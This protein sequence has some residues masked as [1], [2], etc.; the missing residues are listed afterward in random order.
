MQRLDFDFASSSPKENVNPIVSA[1]GL[2]AQYIQSEL[3]LKNIK[4]ILNPASAVG[5]IGPSGCGKSTLLRCLNLLHLPNA[6]TITFKSQTTFDDGKI[7]VDEASLR[8]SIGLV[9][10]GFNLWPNKD[11][12]SNLIE[13]PIIVRRVPR[14]IAVDMAMTNLRELNLDKF[15]KS[16]PCEL[17]G[18]Q[19]QKVALMRAIIMEPE[20]LLLDEITSALDVE[21]TFQVLEI[22]QK[23][24]SRGVSLLYVS[25][26][27]DLIRNLTDN[28]VVMNNGEIVESGSTKDVL[29][30]PVN[31]FTQ[32]FLGKANCIR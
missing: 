25:H 7:L 22:C 19:K 5:I 16:Y 10:Q 1:E 28:L 17:S 13:A 23:L 29:G 30:A 6:G 12:L 8:T 11:V 26:N 32:N 9:H 18:G 21:S 15:A 20:V 14:S 27:L 3:V 24:R 2:S 4:I 31:R